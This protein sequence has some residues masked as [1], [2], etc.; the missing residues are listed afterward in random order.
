MRVTTFF[1]DGVGFDR[2]GL[3]RDRRGGSGRGYGG[4]QQSQSQ[5]ETDTKAADTEPSIADLLGQALGQYHGETAYGF[6]R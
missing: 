4:R 3:S 6:S 2:E 5:P 1:S